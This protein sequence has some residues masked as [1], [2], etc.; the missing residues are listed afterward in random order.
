LFLKSGKIHQWYK[1]KGFL[2]FG[3]VVAVGGFYWEL[4]C[5]YGGQMVLCAVWNAYLLLTNP[6]GMVFES[7]GA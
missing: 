6:F 2:V 5:L 7:V 3:A 1:N 4:K